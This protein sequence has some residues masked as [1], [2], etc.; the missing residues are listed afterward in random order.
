MSKLTELLAAIVEASRQ[1]QN[2]KA[3]QRKLDAMRER[4]REAEQRLQQNCKQ[5][6]ST[7]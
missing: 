4:L 3:Q 6:G 7:K 1:E 5:K 2:A